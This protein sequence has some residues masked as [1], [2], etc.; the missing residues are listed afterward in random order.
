MAGDVPM[1]ERA[2]VLAADAE[3]GAPAG[4][5]GPGGRVVHRFGPRVLIGDLPPAVH[6]EVE[7]AFKAKVFRAGVDTDA[8]VAAMDDLDDVGAM[9]LA[10]LRLRESAGFAEAKSARPHAGASWDTAEATSPDP[11]GAPG[12]PF[13]GVVDAEAPT[14]KPT[15]TLGGPTSE[16]MTGSIAVGVVIVSGPTAELEFTE[17]ERTKVVAEVQNGLAWLAAQQPSVGLVW[18]Y[19][20]RHVTIDTPPGP[21]TLD[22]DGRELLWRDPATESMGFGT[23][24]EAVTGYVQHLLTTLATE[25][26][27]CVFFTKY[28]VGHF[29]Y[30][31]SPRL[32]MQYANDGWGPDNIDRV[33]AHETGHIFGAPDEYGS[34]RCDC[35]GEFGYFRQPNGNCETCA[36]SGGVPCI[37]R[38]NTWSMCAYTP[39]HLGW[40][41]NPIAQAGWR[42]CS[43]CRSMTFAAGGPAPCAAG[44]THDDAGSSGYSVVFQARAPVV[45]GG[46][47]WCAKCQGMAFAGGG[48]GPC[49]AGGAHDHYKSGDYRMLQGLDP[50]VGEAGWRWC[51]K[52]QGLAFAGGGPGP[53]P[54]GGA[55]DHGI[56]GPYAVPRDVEGGGITGQDGWRRCAKCQGLV[57][58]PGGEGACPGGG[59]HDHEASPPYTVLHEVTEPAF[60]D[61]WRWCRKCHALAFAGRGPGPCPAGGGHDH[62]WSANY[63]L[64]QGLGLAQDGW[65]WCAKCYA[66][67]YPAGAKPAPC[68]AGGTHDPNANATYTMLQT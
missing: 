44:G 32:V 20:V 31:G 59:T 15:P 30:A 5:A 46:W 62:G 67:V 36:Q 41:R 38:G 55:H 29:A 66:L 21:D 49:P 9:G 34:A 7:V 6:E 45:Q 18:S 12:S 3:H 61:N 24:W 60:Q 17:D 37:M 16:R 57:Y 56:S 50:M 63:T 23:G 2:V 10:A 47:R 19:D 13:A 14:A 39:A 4:P 1:S 58:A 26:A 43:K 8:L 28:P 53:C 54:A 52:C 22:F 40:E 25:W 51:R 42:W 64:L 68:P 35:G 11:P 33:F 48:P 27:Y 65:R